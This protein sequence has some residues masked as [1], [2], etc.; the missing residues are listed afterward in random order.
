MADD[1]KKSKIVSDEG[2]KE[3]ARKEKEKLR[4]PKTPEPPDAAA[5]EAA[6]DAVASV[7]EESAGGLPPASFLMLVQSY[8][9][10]TLYC[11]GMLKLP[12]TEEA[13]VNLDAAKHNIDMLHVIEDKTKGNLAEEEEQFL[14]QI[15]HEVRMAY[16][17]VASPNE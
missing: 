13:Q 3:E 11:L 17:Q 4:E 7:G 16:M 10:Q 12:G 15:L 6:G 14:G 9:I 2:W 1:E 8:R 5:D